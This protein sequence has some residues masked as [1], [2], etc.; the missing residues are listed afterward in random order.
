M[1]GVWIG[2]ADALQL[3]IVCISDSYCVCG[4][5]VSVVQT[6]DFVADVQIRIVGSSVGD[7]NDVNAVRRDGET[8]RLSEHEVTDALCSAS[9]VCPACA[10][11]GVAVVD[12]F[13]SITG[14]CPSTA[15]VVEAVEAKFDEIFVVECHNGDL[16]G[17][18][19]RGN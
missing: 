4:N 18:A 11:S 5:A 10:A 1:E 16:D 9:C 3:G 2:V 6:R 17:A 14:V 15:R 19:E 13:D 8:A 12:R 7:E